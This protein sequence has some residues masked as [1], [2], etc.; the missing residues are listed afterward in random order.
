M[1]ILFIYFPVDSTV[2]DSYTFVLVKNQSIHNT[3][4]RLRSNVLNYISSNDLLVDFVDR[5]ALQI[6]LPVILNMSFT[7]FYVYS[8]LFVHCYSFDE[9][10]NTKVMIY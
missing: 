1:C 7:L 3:H 10:L 2:L 6:S 5:F 8:K 4:M 9:L